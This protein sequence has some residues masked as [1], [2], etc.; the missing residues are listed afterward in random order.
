MAAD[1]EIRIRHLTLVLREQKDNLGAA[2]DKREKARRDGAAQEVI[3]QITERI[4]SIRRLMRD[5]ERDLKGP[6]IEP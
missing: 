1:E 2:I 6:G 5:T 3:G 4:D